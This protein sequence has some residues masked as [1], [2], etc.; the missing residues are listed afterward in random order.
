MKGGVKRS[1]R[2]KSVMVIDKE[3]EAAK[4]P[5]KQKVTQRD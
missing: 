5:W 4:M 1:D 2:K 3:K